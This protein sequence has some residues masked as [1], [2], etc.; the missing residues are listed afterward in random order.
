MGQQLLIMK[1]QV[2]E[3][4]IPSRKIEAQVPL[5]GKILVTEVEIEKPK[6]LLEELPVKKPAEVRGPRDLV[7]GPESSGPGPDL[8][9]RKVDPLLQDFNP[10]IAEDSLRNAEP[11]PL[12]PLKQSEP[13]MIESQ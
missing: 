6:P 3:N 1:G 2:I 13:E 7:S 12:T 4:L 11:N 8:I 5:V 10:D 9:R